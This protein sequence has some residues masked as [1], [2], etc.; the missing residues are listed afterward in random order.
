MQVSRGKQKRK[1]IA[2][3]PRRHTR[4]MTTDAVRKAVF[5]TSELLEHIIAFLPPKDILTRV[6]GL[7]RQWKNAVDSSPTIRNKLWMTSGKTGAVQSTGFT[8]EHIPGNPKWGQDARPMYSCALTLNS[9]LFNRAFFDRESHALRLLLKDQSLASQ[10]FD[11]NGVVWNFLT[12]L[13]ECYSTGS[14]QQTGP[15]LSATWRSMFLTSPPI[16]RIM[17]ELH[18]SPT[19]CYGPHDIWLHLT[20]HTGITLGLLYDTL[21][22]KFEAQ[23]GESATSGDVKHFWA[24]LHFVSASAS[25]GTSILIDE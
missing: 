15:V 5:N 13:L 4:S 18:P 6:R 22:A 21:F 11:H 20:D 1:A 3:T 25:L 8:D 9:A 17:L 24:S 10:K 19:A 12:I 2:A 16:T 14:F 23:Y 7:S